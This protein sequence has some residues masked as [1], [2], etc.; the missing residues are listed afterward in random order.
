MR[1]TVKI[2]NSVIIDP[3]SQHGMRQRKCS[4]TLVTW[5]N[6]LLGASCGFTSL[7]HRRYHS[8]FSN[9]SSLGDRVIH[10][11]T[12]SNWSHKFCFAWRLK[13]DYMCWTCRMYFL[14]MNVVICRE[15]MAVW[16]CSNY[17]SDTFYLKWE[18]TS[19]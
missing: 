19:K 9:V 8:K 17:D 18:F 6:S 16:L 5:R 14:S 12:D 3:H 1:D 7:K 13:S 4:T 11:V 15:V 2:M 10:K